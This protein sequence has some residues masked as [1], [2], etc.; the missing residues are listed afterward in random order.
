M[1]KGQNPRS[2]SM[3]KLAAM[4]KQLK[5]ATSQSGLQKIKTLLKS[6]TSGYSGE[7]ES[8]EIKALRRKIAIRENALLKNAN[9][10]ENKQFP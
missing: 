2:S 9:K 4:D 6:Y 10:R 7:T 5:S 8:K 1:P 3:A